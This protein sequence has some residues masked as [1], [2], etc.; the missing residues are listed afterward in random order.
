MDSARHVINLNYDPHF[1]TRTASHDEASTV[2]QSPESQ[3]LEL[4]GII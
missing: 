2:H 3:V 1:L 4:N